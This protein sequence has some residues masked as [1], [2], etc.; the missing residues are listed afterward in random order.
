MVTIGILAGALI[1]RS[2]WGYRR[3][4]SSVTLSDG[5]L[6]SLVL[7]LEVSKYFNGLKR[8]NPRLFAAAGLDA[9]KAELVDFLI[10]NDLEVRVGGLDP[11]AED[12]AW[13]GYSDV[14]YL[15]KST[16]VRMTQHKHQE[17]V[18]ET[19]H[20]YLDYKYRWGYYRREDEGI[21]NCV[22]LYHLETY[23]DLLEAW[24]LQQ[25]GDSRWRAK[26]DQFFDMRA[27]PEDFFK[28]RI[29]VNEAEEMTWDDVDNT[30]DEF[31]IVVDEAEI[32]S[33]FGLP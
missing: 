27:N 24:E 21:A 3:P 29:S 14:M 17:M 28:V 9:L 25:R 22:E 13:D 5:R 6:A 18:H 15:N 26:L 10:E 31:G 7:R 23:H 12:A 30:A 4:G 33:I 8:A 20:A 11:M 2:R 19:V 1:V 32:R 16:F